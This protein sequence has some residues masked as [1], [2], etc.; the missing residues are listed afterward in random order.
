MKLLK[1][2]VKS[3]DKTI[4]FLRKFLENVP[5]WSNEIIE[6]ETL[7]IIENTLVIG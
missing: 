2:K 4:L 3:Q 1:L 7:R 5:S 6:N